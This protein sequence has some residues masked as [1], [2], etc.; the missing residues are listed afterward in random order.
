MAV[1]TPTA[2]KR[3]QNLN[4]AGLIAPA[5]IVLAVVIGYPILRAVWLSFQGNRHLNPKTG[6]FEEGGFVKRLRTTCTGSIT[7]VFLA[8]GRS[9]S[10]LL[11]LSPRTSGRR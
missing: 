8:P 6:I 2:M 5:L 9:R 3:K 10:A 4:A 7:V 11:A 1:T